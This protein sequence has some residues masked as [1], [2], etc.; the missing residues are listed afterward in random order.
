MKKAVLPSF[1]FHCLASIVNTHNLNNSG[2]FN[3]KKFFNQAYPRSFY[4]K[5]SKK[6]RIWRIRT[7][8]A[9]VR[10][11]KRNFSNAISLH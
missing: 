4:V 1:F 5:D 6:G 7:L 9:C 8:S 3:K 10:I 11:Q 2:E